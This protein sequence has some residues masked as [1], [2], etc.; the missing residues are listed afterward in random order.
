MYQ[1]IC[2]LPHVAL[3]DSNERG[4]QR[5]SQIHVHIISGLQIYALYLPSSVE[6]N[7]D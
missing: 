4:H 1:I 7:I 3:T 6:A 2:T 5:Q